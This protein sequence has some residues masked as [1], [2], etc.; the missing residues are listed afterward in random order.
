MYW[1][2]VSFSCPFEAKMFY[3]V[4]GANINAVSGMT[5]ETVLGVAC[6]AGFYDVVEML[7]KNGAMLE[8]GGVTPL[9]EAAREG[10]QDLVHYLL[11]CGANVHTLSAIG[12][13]ALH[14]ACEYGHTGVANLLLQFGANLVCILIYYQLC[15]LLYITQHYLCFSS[16]TVTTIL[17][18]FRNMSLK[19]VIPH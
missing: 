4:I 13:T 9:M 16:I 10:N 8:H 3:F 5:Y 12:D 15:C 2:L 1:Y 18:F 11:E 19:M 6:C 14:Y 7:V 17:F